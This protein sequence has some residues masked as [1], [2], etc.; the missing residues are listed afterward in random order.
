MVKIIITLSIF[1]QTTALA[2]SYWSIDEYVTFN[3][4]QKELMQNLHTLVQNDAKP[5]SDEIEKVTISML[6]PGKQLTDYWRRNDVAF[7]ARMD[8][9]KIPYEINTL[10]VD[11]NDVKSLQQNLLKLLQLQSDYL[12]FTLNIDGHKRLISQIINNQKPK[13]ILQNITTPLKEWGANQPFFYVG[14][15]H[16]EGT[17]L[18]AS[19]MQK[20]FDKEANYLMLYHNEGY[21]SQMRG[22]GFIN[23]VNNFHHINGAFYTYVDKEVAKNIVLNYENI[24]QI[25]YIYSCSTDIA[26]G[27][28]EA[29]QELGLKN[30]IFLNGWGGGETELAM[31]ENDMLDMTVMRINDDSAVAMAEA[32]KLDL[33]G[34]EVPLIYSG[35]FVV[36]DSKTDKQSLEK[37]KQRAFRYSQ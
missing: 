31:I 11:E 10:F 7:R 33:L 1:L 23:L 22:D 20:R 14:F 3:P 34:K 36:I 30:K 26:I 12:V 35:G 13:I 19:H 6:F 9:L 15:D 2:N 18:L 32:I 25:D 4:K 8:A 29:L 17:K 21:V 27:A 5:I 28:S 16:L 37:L 24:D